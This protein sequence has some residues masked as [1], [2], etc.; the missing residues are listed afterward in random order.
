MNYLNVKFHF[1]KM[2]FVCATLWS[3]EEGVYLMEIDMASRA[4]QVGEISAPQDK[5][6]QLEDDSCEL[7]MLN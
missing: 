5:N 6:H 3:E 7:T 4:I 2:T 1:R